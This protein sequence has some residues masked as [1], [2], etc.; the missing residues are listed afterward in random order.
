MDYS[1][2][3]EEITQPLVISQLPEVTSAG[4]ETVG[5]T[6]E[7]VRPP[8]PANSTEVT[9]R[10]TLL[11]LLLP[12]HRRRAGLHPSLQAALRWQEL[13]RAAARW[14]I[15]EQGRTEQAKP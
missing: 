2:L 1:T 15:Y 9:V 8:P 13:E 6:A 5:S 7:R 4:T 14:R 3:G 11:S 10:Q 12:V